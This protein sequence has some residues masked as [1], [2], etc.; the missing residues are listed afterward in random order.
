MGCGG[1]LLK[2]LAAGD[3]VFW[4]IFTVAREADWPVEHIRQSAEQV[5]TVSQAYG[6]A[7]V[8]KLGFPSTRLDTVPKREIVEGFYEIVKSVQ[9]QRVYTVGDTDVHTDH[10][11]TFEAVML[12]LKPFR[13]EFK[14]NAIYAY[15]VL[16]STEAAFG[17]RPHVFVP[18]VYSNITLFLERKLEIMALFGNQLQSEWLPRSPTSLRALARYRGAA[19]GVEYAEAFRLVRAVF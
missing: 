2:H 10:C 6:F 1:T 15:E 16:S 12:A 18:N 19:I 13:V 4:T 7:E 9:P 11:L 5:E 17:F 14:V 3:E 8:F